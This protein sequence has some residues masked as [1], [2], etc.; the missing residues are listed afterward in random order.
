MSIAAKKNALEA[1][2]TELTEVIIDVYLTPGGARELVSCTNFG[3]SILS[4]IEAD[5]CN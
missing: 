5:S 2:T 3:M 1:T 4:C